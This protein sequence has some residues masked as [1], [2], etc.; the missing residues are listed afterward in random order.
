M[1][2]LIKGTDWRDTKHRLRTVRVLTVYP[3]VVCYAEV[4]PRTGQIRPGTYT[5]GIERFTA[6]FEEIGR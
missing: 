6:R 2:R 4:D 1:K 3:L 5:D